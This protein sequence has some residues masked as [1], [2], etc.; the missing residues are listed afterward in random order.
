MAAP[1]TAHATIRTTGNPDGVESGRH[2]AEPRACRSA[3]DTADQ[4]EDETKQGTERNAPRAC[5]AR[6]C[7]RRRRPRTRP[8]CRPPRD[9]VARTSGARP[10]SDRCR[11]SNEP[12]EQCAGHA[13]HRRGVCAL[14]HERRERQHLRRAHAPLHVQLDRALRRDPELTAA[15]APCRDP[16]RPTPRSTHSAAPEMTTPV[17]RSSSRIWRTCGPSG[18]SSSSVNCVRCSPR[19]VVTQPRMQA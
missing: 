3:R 16:C 15:F 1:S 2:A 12:R 11:G 19:S 7:R 9:R 10:H 6:R 5:A 18:R 14:G 4:P 13:A 8:A 17:P